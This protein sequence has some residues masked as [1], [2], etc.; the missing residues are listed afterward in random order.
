LPLP[1]KLQL[2]QEVIVAIFCVLWQIQD[3]ILYHNLS[4]YVALAVKPFKQCHL[5]PSF[6]FILMPVVVL[7]DQMPTEMGVDTV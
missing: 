1:K 2:S 6:V 7:V 4:Q 3:A 5:Q